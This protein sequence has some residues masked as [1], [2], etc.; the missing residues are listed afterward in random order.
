MRNIALLSSYWFSHAVID[1]VC[2]GTLFWFLLQYG[3]DFQLSLILILLY[4]ILAFWLQS[5]IGIIADYF[6][7]SKSLAFL[8][9]LFV[10]WGPLFFFLWLPYLTVLFLWIGNA[11]FHVWWGVVTLALDP[12]KASYPWLFVAPW[13]LGLFLWTM[14][15]MQWYYTWY[16]SLVLLCLACI[17]MYYSSKNFDAYQHILRFSKEHSKKDFLIP[18][19]LIITMLLI[20]IVIRSF[21]WFIVNFSWKSGFI[22]SLGFVICIVLGKALWGVLADRFWW[23]KVWVAS[24]LLSLPCLFFWELSP[25]IWMIGIFLFNITMPISFSW[26]VIAKPE[27]SWS[28][29]WLLCLALL[30]GALPSLLQVDYQ[31]NE[32]ILLVYF[33]LLSAFLVYSAL[34]VLRK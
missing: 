27:K 33:I 20:S 32:D 24:L 18:I 1:F 8:W 31:W 30:I 23:K 6:K 5:I 7:F 9:C 12:W 22:I 21:V 10:A 34:T 28:L 29:F 14:A 13:A 4:N 3:V 26:M 2:T 11:L 15:W 25:L 19:V 17:L 16:E